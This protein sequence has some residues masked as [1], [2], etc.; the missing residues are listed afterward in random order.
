MN[1]SQ[2]S[3]IMQIVKKLGWNDMPALIALDAVQIMVNNYI[4]GLADCTEDSI[5]E[6]TA[7]DLISNHLEVDNIWLTLFIYDYDTLN[8]EE[9]HQQ[10]L[11]LRWE[12]ES[13]M[14]KGD[15]F[16]EARREWDV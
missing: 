13:Y 1:K 12:I 2:L 7:L 14:R 3:A 6:D 11:S 5:C 15:T 8:D 16:T 10:A 4:S 9:M